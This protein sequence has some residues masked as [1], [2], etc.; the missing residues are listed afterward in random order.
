MDIFQS[1]RTYLALLG[2]HSPRIQ[3][4][5]NSVKGLMVLVL[6]GLTEISTCIFFLYQAEILEEYAQAFYGALS[7]HTCTF[8]FGIYILKKQELFK[9]MKNMEIVIQKSEL[10]QI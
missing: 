9:F 5:S 1:I 3:N 8:G 2:V 10:I 7:M 6:M 4:H